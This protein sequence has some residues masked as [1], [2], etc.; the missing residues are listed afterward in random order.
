MVLFIK[1]V[2]LPSN[3]VALIVKGEP[4]YEDIC[5]KI[6]EFNRPPWNSGLIEG[7]I[8]YDRLTKSPT[9]QDV[10]KDEFW[11]AF[12]EMLYELEKKV[13]KKVEEKRKEYQS[14]KYKTLMKK[15]EDIFSQVKREVELTTWFDGK[16]TSVTFIL[17]FLLCRRI[18]LL[19]SAR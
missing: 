2:F 11:D 3:Q 7:I 15:L 16:K 12:L 9:R 18:A 5:Q 13:R 1:D 17:R 6:P 10:V 4:V 8:Q 19:F 14:K